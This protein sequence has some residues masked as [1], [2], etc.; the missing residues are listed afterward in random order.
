MLS[1]RP[2]GIYY[3]RNPP[4][5][6]SFCIVSLRSD[7]TSVQEIGATI[8]RIWS[9][10]SKLKRGVTIEF[11]TDIRHR[12]IGNLSV[13]LGYGPNVF[14]IA[15][16]KKARPKNFASV[17]NFIKPKREGG[18][19]VL[20]GSDMKYFQNVSENH[21]LDDHLI[22]QFIADNE[23]YTNRAAIEV[24]REL[25]MVEK[26]IGYKPLH[27]T[28]FYTGFQRED[29]R[30]WLG[31]HDGISNLKSHERPHVIFINPRYVNSQDKWTV[32]GTYLA[33]MRIG[34]DLV[35]WDD[36]KVKEQEIIIGRDKATGCPIERDI[37]GRP[38]KIRGCPAPSTSEVIDVGNERFRDRPKYADKILQHSHIGSTRSLDRTP[39]WDSKSFR[40]YR[41]GFEF[42]VPSKDSVSIVPGLNFVS[43]QNSPE[44][45]FRAL[46]YGNTISREKVKS[47]IPMGLNEFLSVI[48]AGI[49][50]VPPLLQ[51]EPFP[52]AEIFGTKELRILR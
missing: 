38:V 28:G 6:N 31:F 19:P 4:I 43:F 35:R 48:S 44:R 29:K 21:L 25:R 15:G 33:F 1:V 22:F 41:Q 5:G 10:L 24:W 7:N 14:G 34:I 39:V 36:T 52:G 18:G 17:W 30:N 37:Y 42:L 45:L 50:L 32:N 11:E 40:I 3:R 47:T 46:T 8:A 13:L 9:R 16:S 27:L 49:F 26:E 51:G 2:E 20:E 12:K 23:F